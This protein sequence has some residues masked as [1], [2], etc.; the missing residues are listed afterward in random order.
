MKFFTN[1][2]SNG[3]GLQ[4]WN[5]DATEVN[6]KSPADFRGARTLPVKHIQIDFHWVDFTFGSK[7]TH[8]LFQDCA[9]GSVKQQIF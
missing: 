8:L 3:N 6:G 4:E 5:P 2:I 7:L 1:I 9:S